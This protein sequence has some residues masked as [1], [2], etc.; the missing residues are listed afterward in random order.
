M[1]HCAL[2]LM[3]HEWPGRVGQGEMKGGQIRVNC[4][5]LLETVH[6]W[7]VFSNSQ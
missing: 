3:T 6:P 7:P 2:E 5:S 1:T 4:P